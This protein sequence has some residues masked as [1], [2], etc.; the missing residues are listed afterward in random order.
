MAEPPILTLGIV[1]LTA[2]LVAILSRRLHLSYSVGPVIAGI[3]LVL[4]PLSIDLSLSRDL[5]FSVFL[6][7]LVFSDSSQSGGLSLLQSRCWRT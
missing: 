6:P 1:L 5:I 7:P 4:V 3:V 2:S